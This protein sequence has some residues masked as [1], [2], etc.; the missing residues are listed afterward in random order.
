MF[1]GP[2]PLLVLFFDL[3]CSPPLAIE[4]VQLLPLA[5]ADADRDRGRSPEQRANRLAYALHDISQRAL[6]VEEPSRRQ[7]WALGYSDSKNIQL[8]DGHK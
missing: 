4:V 6:K 1:V 8:Y 2:L 7:V 5:P 3:S